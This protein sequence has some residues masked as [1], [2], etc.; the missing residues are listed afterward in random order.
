MKSEEY[1][2]KKKNVLSVLVK[3]NIFIEMTISDLLV[4]VIINMVVVW[5]G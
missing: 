4:P 1:S 5:T 2:K 3:F